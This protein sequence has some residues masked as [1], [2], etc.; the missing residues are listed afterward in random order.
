MLVVSPRP[1]LAPIPYLVCCKDHRTTPHSLCHSSHSCF[2]MPPVKCSTSPGQT[3]CQW[4]RWW[5]R[6]QPAVMAP[7][8]REPTWGREAPAEDLGEWEGREGG[9]ERRHSQDAWRWE[10]AEERV[11]KQ[12]PEGSYNC[13][14]APSAGARPRATTRPAKL[15]CRG[16]AYT[17]GEGRWPRVSLTELWGR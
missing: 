7:G 1:A 16:G 17:T 13:T 14:T 15:G 11:G 8:F 12:A 2:L 10:R 5:S 9:A 4:G 3:L 6:V